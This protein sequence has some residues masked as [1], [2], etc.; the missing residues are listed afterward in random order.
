MTINWTEIILALLGT[1]GITLITSVLLFKQKKK[2]VETEID[3]STLDN[4]EKGFALQ[5]AQLKKAIGDMLAVKSRAELEE[6]LRNAYQKI[7][8]L[9]NEMNSIKNELKNAKEDRDKLKKQIDKLNKP[10]TR[11]TRTKNVSKTE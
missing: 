3:S 6:S 1:N 10:T 2:K 4:L 11:K 5:G 7:Q 8:E 9:Y